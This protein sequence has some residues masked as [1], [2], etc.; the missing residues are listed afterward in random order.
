[1]VIIG[2]GAAELSAAYVLKKNGITPILLDAEAHVGGRVAEDSVG[3]FTL[4]SGADF[5]CMT[6]R[7]LPSVRRV[8]IA[9]GSLQDEAGLAQK[10]QVGNDDA[11]LSVGNLARNLPAA[12]ALGFLSP[13]VM[14]PNMK[15]FRGIF[16]Q[17]K[18]LNFASD[19]RIA[20][21]DGPESFGEYLTGLGISE[22]LQMTFRGFLEMTM[23]HVEFP[24]HAYMR[25]YLAEMLLKADRLAVPEKGANALR[26]GMGRCL[27]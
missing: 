17:A 9:A 19:S 7:R 22:S 11:G 16:S 1:M 14:W 25:T 27:L 20:E 21:L 8:G 3:D 2:G 13:R 12:R 23:G 4:D 26:A 24:G 10:R 15:L 6:Y 18:Y 5:F